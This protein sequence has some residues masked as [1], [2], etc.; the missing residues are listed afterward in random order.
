MLSPLPAVEDASIAVQAVAPGSTKSPAWRPPTTACAR[1]SG[2]LEPIDVEGM[3]HRYT[4][5]RQL[6]PARGLRR[7]VDARRDDRRL[8]PRRVARPRRRRPDLRPHDVGRAICLGAR[9]RRRPSSAGASA[10]AREIAAGNPSDRA[11]LDGPGSRS[12]ATPSSRARSSRPGTSRVRWD[13]EMLRPDLEH[14]VEVPIADSYVLRNAHR[15]RAA[16]RLR[17]D[18]RGLRRAL[19][20][21]RGERAAPRRVDRES[22]LPAGPDRHRLEGR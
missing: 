14:I 1:T 15:S 18:R 13:A 8:R 19:G 22:G 12:A 20:A 11:D 3:R 5:P 6:G 9:R 7:R 17:D 16:G 10:G 4:A 21:V 2:V